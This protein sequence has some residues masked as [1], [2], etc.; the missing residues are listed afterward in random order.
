LQKAEEEG[1][2]IYY[3][4]EEDRYEKEPVRDVS[5]EELDDFEWSYVNFYGDEDEG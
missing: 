1:Q 5:Q 3:I 2:E 4:I